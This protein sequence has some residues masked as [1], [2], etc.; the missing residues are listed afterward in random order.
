MKY[1]NL[2]QSFEYF[3]ATCKHVKTRLSQERNR[4]AVIVALSAGHSYLEIVTFLKLFRSFIF[5][6]RSKLK[7]ARDNVA[8]VSYWKRHFRESVIIRMP[9]LVSCV[10]ENPRTSMRA[11]S[12]DLKVIDDTYGL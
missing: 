3:S 9:K 7:T 10:D 12:R 6:V 4:N 1:L 5:K 8:N 11:F 2:R